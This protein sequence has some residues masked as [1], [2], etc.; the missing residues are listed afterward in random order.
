MLVSDWCTLC[1]SLCMGGEGPSML[2]PI[3]ETNRRMGQ[4]STDWLGI[5]ELIEIEDRR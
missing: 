5:D 2:F 1:A 4:R 3:R